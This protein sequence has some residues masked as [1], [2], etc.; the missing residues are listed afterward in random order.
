MINFRRGKII[1]KDYVPRESIGKDIILGYRINYKML[2]FQTTENGKQEIGSESIA[3]NGDFRS[4]LKIVGLGIQDI[5]KN[6][7]LKVSH[8]IKNEN[9]RKQ[10]E[11]G[12]LQRKT[13]FSEGFYSIQR[14]SRKKTPSPRDGSLVTQ[15][16]QPFEAPS[17]QITQ[18]TQPSHSSMCPL[19]SRSQLSPDT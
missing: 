16:N 10:A 6:S 12:R 17:S 14:R 13:N 1:V 3:R 18:P 5:A 7:L 2:W 19:C 11:W 15:E 9:N 4:W 8:R